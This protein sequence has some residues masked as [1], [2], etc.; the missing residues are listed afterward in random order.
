MMFQVGDLYRLERAIALALLRDDQTIEPAEWEELAR[1]RANLRF[2]LAAAAKPARPELEL[3]RAGE[4]DLYRLERAIALALLRAGETIEP[5]EREELA[6]L[7]ANLRFAIAAAGRPAPPEL[8]LCPECAWPKPAGLAC[9]NC[10]TY[11]VDQ[12]R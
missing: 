12:D 8:E 2:T 3:F 6:R 9:P 4:A 1:L 11:V 10:Q 7:R 5:A